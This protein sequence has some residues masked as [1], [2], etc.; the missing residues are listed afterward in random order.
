MNKWKIEDAVP[1]PDRFQE[2]RTPW[3][4]LEKKGQ[5]VFV[6]AIGRKP[7]N[8]AVC[9]LAWARPKGVKFCTEER[10]DNGKAGVRV[11]RVK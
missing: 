2:H 4:L 1:L 6:E 9:A 5:S 11:W 10:V 8:I 7:A 3:P